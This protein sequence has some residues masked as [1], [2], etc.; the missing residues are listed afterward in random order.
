MSRAMGADGHVQNRV[1]LVCDDDA[2]AIRLAERLLDAF[3]IELWQLGP[4]GREVYCLGSLISDSACS[5][6]SRSRSAGRPFCSHSSRAR[7]VISCLVRLAL[8]PDIE[9]PVLFS[10]HLIGDG[11]KMFEHAAS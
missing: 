3:D 2:E 9:L 10:E 6:N 5:Q 4:I 11:Q 1:D 8:R 7:A